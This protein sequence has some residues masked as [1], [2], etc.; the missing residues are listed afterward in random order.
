MALDGAEVRR[1]FFS[2]SFLQA[3]VACAPF[4]CTRTLTRQIIREAVSHGTEIAS[5]STSSR[6]RRWGG[7]R[8]RERERDSNRCAAYKLRRPINRLRCLTLTSCRVLSHFLQFSPRQSSDC[9]VYIYECCC[10]S[11]AGK[12][13]PRSLVAAGWSCFSRPLEH[14]L[15]GSLLRRRL[16]GVSWSSLLF[17]CF[18]RSVLVRYCS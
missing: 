7:E 12:P 18:R 1:L 9:A 16:T 3:P 14:F 13:I 11:R 17:R 4:C 8:E 5:P 10:S 6:R 15:W 2:S